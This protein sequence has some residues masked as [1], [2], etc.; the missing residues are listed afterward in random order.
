MISPSSGTPTIGLGRFIKEN[1]VIVPSHQRDYSWTEEYVSEF[2]HDIEEALAMNR[3]NYF[4]GLMVF[5]STG[6]A[7]F[8]VLDGQQRLATTLMIFS[9]VRNWFGLF[10]E[11]ARWKNQAQDYLESEELGSQITEPRL[12]LTAANNDAFQQ[13]VIKAVPP[14]EILK[15]IRERQFNDRSMTLLSAATWI[16]RYIERRA[17]EFSSPNNAKDFF[18]KL[19]VFLSDSV[20]IVQFVPESD[21]AAYTIFETLNDRGLELSPLDLVKNYLFSHAEKHRK[22]SL[23]EFEERWTEMMS[24]LSSPRADSFL[25]A[26]WA[27]RYGK[28]EGAKLFTA[29][30]KIHNTPEALYQISIDLRRDAEI[31]CTV[32][33]RRSDVVAIFC[34]ASPQ[35]GSDRNYR[36]FSVVFHGPRSARKVQSKGNG[37]SI[38]AY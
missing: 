31:C 21:D 11:Y 18:L 33:V 19:L 23:Q 13:C 16:N 4:C 15:A 26:F 10:G 1:H 8:K 6:S 38:A 3:T 5:T 12:S 20:R 14:N 32:Y 22:G 7:K 9:A 34:L 27:S 30:K 37:T 17:G 2:M 36:I 29:F 25:R 24:V 28:P 35:R